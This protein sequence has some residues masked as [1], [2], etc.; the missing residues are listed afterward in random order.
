VK[1]LILLIFF[2]AIST[3]FLIFIFFKLPFFLKNSVKGDTAPTPTEFEFPTDVP[4]SP[5]SSVEPTI[6]KI[7]PIDKKTGFDRS[8]LSVEVQN[9]SKE[10][11]AA[12]KVSSF[13]TDLKYHIL[14]IKN[15][16]DF[17]YEGIT[18]K[19]KEEKSKY[20][21]LLK[22]DLSISYSIASFSADLATSSAVDAVVIV[23]K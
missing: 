6:Y 19:L 4:L 15:A 1:K 2:A 13:L 23:G 7:N 5:A 14:S 18:L 16:N 10:E 20:I 17:E 3:T 12:S 22:R 11:F 21:E 9:G 8:N